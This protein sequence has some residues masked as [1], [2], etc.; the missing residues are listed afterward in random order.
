MLPAVSILIFWLEEKIF[1]T[2]VKPGKQK[3]QS[4]HGRHIG[5]IKLKISVELFSDENTY[6]DCGNELKSHAG[7]LEVG[8]C[9]AGQLT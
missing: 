6:E 2:Q 4:R 7:I 8:I 1:E 3:E 5:A 9:F